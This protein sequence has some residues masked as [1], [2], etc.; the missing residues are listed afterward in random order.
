[1][2]L[3]NRLGLL[4]PLIRFYKKR[5]ESRERGTGN[6]EKGKQREDSAFFFLPFP[7][8]PFVAIVFFFPLVK[9]P[10]YGLFSGSFRNW[11]LVKTGILC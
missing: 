1:M 4:V 3:L 7:L 10:A 11:I 8:L 6:K 5:T 9:S 2:D